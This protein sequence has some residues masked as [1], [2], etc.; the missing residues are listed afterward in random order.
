MS[1]PL[2]PQFYLIR[3]ESKQTPTSGKVTYSIVPLIPADQL[4]EWLEIVGVPRTLHHQ[5]ASRMSSVGIVPRDAGFYDVQFMGSDVTHPL[6]PSFSWAEATPSAPVPVMSEAEEDPL[7][8]SSI[9]PPDDE[10]DPWPSPVSGVIPSAE[11]PSV[12]DQGEDNMTTDYS[13]PPSPS[14]HTD[15]K[16]FHDT[17]PTQSASST[18]LPDFRGEG[19]GWVTSE[20]MNCTS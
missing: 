13:P 1:S 2:S 7:S 6:P 17:V 15:A 20:P 16:G 11:E 19:R 8:S 12:Q 3:P 10:N 18:P 9:H 5:Q 4:P 14:I